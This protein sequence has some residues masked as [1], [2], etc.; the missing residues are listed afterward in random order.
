MSPLVRPAVAVLHDGRD[1]LPASAELDELAEVRPAEADRLAEV[2]PGAD[3]L[4]AW[5]FSS[6][7]V[8]KAWQ[9]ADSL[10]WVHSASAGVDRLLF[11]GLLDSDAVLTNSRGVF[12]QPIAEYVLGLILAFAKGFVETIDLQR[13]NHWQHRETERIA[14]RHAL[15][16]GTGPIGRAT[17][18]LLR[19]A[20]LTVEGV[21]RRPR[22]A[23][24]DLGL[25]HASENLLDALPRA[26][27]VVCAAPLTPAT[28]GMID[29]TAFAAMRPTARFINVGR[30]PLVVEDDLI[31]ALRAGSLAGAALDVV[32]QE[33]L[34]PES[35]LWT[36]PNVIVSPHMSGDVTGWRAELFEL[37]LANLRRYRAGDP[38]EN[39]VDKNRGYVPTG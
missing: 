16:I 39:V 38:L 1:P 7:Q 29:A 28:R 6:G 11:P 26:D 22:Q 27:F 21:G 3:V 17:G 34:S 35:P 32:A 25:V 2:L 19:A 20:G 36:M 30:G 24:V 14:G 8:E 33:P 9:A 18:R 12:D 31:A 23:D 13:R 10:R 37:F 4:L 5:D 15:I